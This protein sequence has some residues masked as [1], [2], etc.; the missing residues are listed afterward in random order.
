MRR[1][2]RDMLGVGNSSGTRVQVTNAVARLIMTSRDGRLRHVTDSYQLRGRRE[3]AFAA[4]ITLACMHRHG[5][6]QVYY[7][8]KVVVV[9]VR[10]TRLMLATLRR[11]LLVA[12]AQTGCVC[13]YEAGALVNLAVKGQ[14]SRAVDL[15]AMYRK[16]GNS[17][18]CE[19][20]KSQFPGLRFFSEVDE[21]SGV[22][23]LLGV[24][25]PENFSFIVYDNGRF[26]STGGTSL[27]TYD[28]LVPAMQKF[29]AE[30][31]A[32][33]G[34]ADTAIPLDSWEGLLEGHCRVTVTD[35]IVMLTPHTSGYFFGD[36]YH[37][38][39]K[40]VLASTG[41]YCGTGY[42]ASGACKGLE[43]AVHTALHP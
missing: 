11:L 40:V 39:T 28:L 1:A 35:D 5:T 20:T 19:Y 4:A 2:G 36:I 34:T 13:T 10:N 29:A 3:K 43:V 12:Y 37:R 21:A 18:F 31:D 25:V 32:F 14:L 41:K 30:F 8:G 7:S 15:Q 16:E 38:N 26:I 42:G 24:P 6:G 17:H 23:T 9:G 27:A 33:T 22:S